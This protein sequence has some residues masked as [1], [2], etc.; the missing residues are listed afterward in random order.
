MLILS[1]YLSFVHLQW[2]YFY[3]DIRL[4]YTEIMKMLFCLEQVSATAF[5]PIHQDHDYAV[6]R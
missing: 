6:V 5:T 3:F 2:F 4:V 1:D